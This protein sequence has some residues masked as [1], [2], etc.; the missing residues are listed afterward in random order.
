MKP[1]FAECYLF[2]VSDPLLFARTRYLIATATAI[3]IKSGLKGR[4]EFRALF[5][6][7]RET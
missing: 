2:F 7:M 5:L 3:G 4:Q 1:E 6:V